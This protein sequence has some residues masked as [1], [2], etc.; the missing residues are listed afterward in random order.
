MGPVLSLI[1][2]FNLALAN[3]LQLIPNPATDS[4]HSAKV[5]T[6]ERLG[7]VLR[8]YELAYKWEAEFRQ[9]QHARE[10]DSSS[11]NTNS[12]N[13]KPELRKQQQPLQREGSDPQ[14]AATATMTRMSAN[15]TPNNKCSSLR[16]D[17]I[18]C[19]NLSEIHR[20]AQNHSKQEKCLQHLL[21]ILMFVVD[22]HRERGEHYNL[23]ADDNDDDASAEQQQQQQQEGVAFESLGVRD[24]NCDTMTPAFSSR[25][26][27]LVDERVHQ[28]RWQEPERSTKR[29]RSTTFMD[30]DG[31]WQNIIPFLLKKDCAGAA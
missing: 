10:K 18:V 23:D 30:L 28:Q 31:F 5:A 29:K 14:S 3:H 13:E 11:S 16:F 22:W 19:N 1:I 20:M 2:T 8:L 9:R 25:E 27:Q 12:C 17:M 24:R 7:K 21:S 15:G 26:H 6:R 4:N